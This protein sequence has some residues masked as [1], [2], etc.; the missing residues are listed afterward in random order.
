MFKLC[1]NIID[2]K[3]MGGNKPPN[4]NIIPYPQYTCPYSLSPTFC[5]ISYGTSHLEKLANWMYYEDTKKE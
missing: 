4:I 1:V 5:S 3:I 2:M